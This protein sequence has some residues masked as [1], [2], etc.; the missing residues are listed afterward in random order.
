MNK[1]LTHI[2]FMA[3]VSG[4]GIAIGFLNLPGDWYAGLNKPFF[5]PPNWLFGPVWTLLY[6][7]IGFVGAR[8]FLLGASSTG[9]KIWSLQMVLNFLWS[10]VFF[11]KQLMGPGLV[12][13]LLLLASII[14]FIA[15]TWNKDRLSASL[16]LPYCVWV[17]F[18]SVLN[19][20]L[21]LLN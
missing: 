18:A 20:S 10:P 1:I 6:L 4:I 3:I 17:S 11:G 7:I 21:L 13:I 15:V 9:F 16:F 14:S 5:N 2:A 19:L 8:Q 12:I